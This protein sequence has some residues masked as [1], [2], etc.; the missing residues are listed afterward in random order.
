MSITS[1]GYG[2]IV[3]VFFEEYI[4][5]ILCQIVGGIIWVT[6]IGCVCN[7]LS[8]CHPLEERFC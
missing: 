3:L 7:T 6:V 8:K 1:I 2:D 5:G 4:A